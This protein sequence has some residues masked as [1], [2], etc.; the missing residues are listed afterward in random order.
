M[1]LVQ[2]RPSFSKIFILGGQRMSI[3]TM[4]KKQVQ[5][6]KPRRVP[7]PRSLVPCPKCRGHFTG[8]IGINRFYCAECCCEFTVGETNLL[9]D[10][11]EGGLVIQI[12]G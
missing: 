6:H 10:L 3:K 5:I 2:A 4:V 9:F 7:T 1:G 8:A 12:A 11:T